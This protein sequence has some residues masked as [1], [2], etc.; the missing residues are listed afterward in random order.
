VTI[1]TQHTD[2][3]PAIGVVRNIKQMS[4][5]KMKIGIEIFTH[6]PNVAILKKFELKKEHEAKA[7][8]TI[9]FSNPEFGGIYIPNQTDAT[10]PA[11][12]ILPK[13][14]YMPNTLYEIVFNKQREIVKFQA[15]IESGDD[16]VRLCF[17][18]E[19]R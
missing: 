10:Q 5:G 12:I 7:E 11:S 18:E 14:E 3:V 6:Q 8:T 1:F 16:W 9:P 17:P 2:S 13:L 4:G 15:P 19:L